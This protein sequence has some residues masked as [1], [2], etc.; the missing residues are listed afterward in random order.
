LELEL[1]RYFTRNEKS[2]FI[3]ER[4]Y[5][6]DLQL[7]FKANPVTP[8]EFSFDGFTYTIN[9]YK[10]ALKDKLFTTLYLDM[11]KTW[12]QNDID[13]MKSLK[14]SHTLIVFVDNE[15]IKLND[16]NWDRI[17]GVLAKYNY[18]VFPFHRISDID[19]S[20]VV[21]KGND[22]SPFLLDFKES[23]FAKNISDFFQAGKQVHLF[24]LSSATSTYIRSLKELRGLQFAKG[25]HEDL[26]ALLNKN[27]FPISGEDERKVVIHDAGLLISRRLSADPLPRNTAPDHLLRLYAYNDIMRRVGPRYFSADFIDEA[28]VE[29][30]ATAYVVS[31]VSSL[32]VLETKEDY[33]RF[34]I[35]HRDN[36]LGNASK[37]S[38]GAVP[39]P[40]EW[41]L[42]AVFLLVVAFYMKKQMVRQILPAK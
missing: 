31:P 40:H 20:L 10:P 12:S 32:V 14:Q 24:N 41:A 36:S 28:L 3:A 15:L 23:L 37:D 42:I 33:K 5:D 2:E 13:K 9:E 4:P 27:Q 21:S 11:N 34:G 26:T 30:A 39:E 22:L 17:T 38:S 1:P 8:G 7:S 16:E 6:P 29:Q 25:T 35:Q 18:S 19:K